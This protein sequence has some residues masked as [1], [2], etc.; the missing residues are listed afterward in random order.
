MLHFTGYLMEVGCVAKSI[1]EASRED[2]SLNFCEDG[3]ECLCDE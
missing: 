2:I 1:F 3:V